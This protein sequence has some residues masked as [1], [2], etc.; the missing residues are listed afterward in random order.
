ML[1]VRA[2]NLDVEIINLLIDNQSGRMNLKESFN[3]KR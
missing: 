2:Y 1:M 3:G